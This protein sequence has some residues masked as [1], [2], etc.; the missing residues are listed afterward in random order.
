MAVAADSIGL[1]NFQFR[2]R[3]RLATKVGDAATDID[4]LAKRATTLASDNGEIGILISMMAGLEAVLSGLRAREILK[5]RALA[6]H[7]APAQPLRI[8]RTG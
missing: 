5:S 8:G 4:D 6:V 7:T 2:I 3:H 1:P